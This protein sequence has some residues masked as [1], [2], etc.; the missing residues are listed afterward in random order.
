MGAL[1]NLMAGQSL[2]RLAALSDGVFAIA[3]TLLVLDLRL[4]ETGKIHSEHDLWRALVLLGPRFIA[5]L[6]SFLTLGIF[7]VG[8]QTQ[9]NRFARADRNLAW[10]HIAFLLFVSIMP[11][12]TALLAGFITYRIALLTYWLNI[13][14]LGVMLFVGWRYARRAELT[15]PDTTEQISAAIERRIVRAQ[16]LY[17]FG[18]LLCVFSTYWSIALIVVIQ[19]NYAIAPRIRPLYRL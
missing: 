10:L 11:F 4:P 15:K 2:E 8:Q 3:M 19:L 16:A 5:Y 9:L 12:S 14:I 6:M 1:Y 7:W 17:A 13:L 18:A